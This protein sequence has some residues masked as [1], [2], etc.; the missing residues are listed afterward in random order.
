MTGHPQ[1]DYS[2]LNAF[3]GPIARPRVSFLYQCGLV[4][5][6]VTMVLLVL[7]YLALIALVAYGVFYHAVHHGF[8]VTEIGS[9]GR[10]FILM[11]LAYL[12]PLVMGT[13]VG[14]FMFKPIFARQPRRAQPLVLNPASE[15]LL[16]AF[17]E[18]ICD[19]VGAPSPRRIDLNCDLNASASF[20]RGFF[21][22][23]SSD[24]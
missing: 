22:M 13:V 18:K 9:R 21:G 23:S 12:A 15:P 17:I 8:W 19:L 24:M 4:L 3:E 6:A 20:R 7:A 11:L 16:Y 10:G 1:R 14:F 2:I 5:V